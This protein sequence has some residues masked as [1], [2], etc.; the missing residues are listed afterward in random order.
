[1]GKRY[2]QLTTAPFSTQKITQ[3]PFVPIK[4][5]DIHWAQTLKM[6]YWCFGRKTIL[7]TPMYIAKSLV[8]I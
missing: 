5:T 7:L 3:K 1:M 4:Y 6:I 2:G 8:N